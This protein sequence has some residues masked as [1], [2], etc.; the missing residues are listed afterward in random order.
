MRSA[1][2]PSHLVCQGGVVLLA[3]QMGAPMALALG[4]F[5]WIE[6]GASGESLTHQHRPNVGP[7]HHSL[8]HDALLEDR[9]KATDSG[10]GQ[11]K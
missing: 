5:R 11:I 2:G 9:V 3:P 1:G 8:G 10:S 6:D 4:G 7:V